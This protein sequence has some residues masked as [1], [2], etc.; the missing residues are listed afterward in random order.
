MRDQ[1]IIQGFEAL[2]RSFKQDINRLAQVFD[3]YL[4]M[5]ALNNQAVKRILVSKGIITQE[6]WVAEV[7][8]VRKEAEAA[9]MKEKEAAVEKP[10]IILP[11]DQQVAAV[12]NSAEGI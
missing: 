1:S 12:E 11:T 10:Q 5:E 9:A 3:L 7:D 4:S 2:E 8:A 6:E